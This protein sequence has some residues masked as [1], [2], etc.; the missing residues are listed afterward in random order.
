[1][2]IITSYVA[3]PSPSYIIRNIFSFSTYIKHLTNGVISAANF[4]GCRARWYSVIHST[5]FHFMFLLTTLWL[6]CTV[7]YVEVLSDFL[8]VC[9]FFFFY[10]FIVNYKIW[11]P[12]YNLF[13]KNI[14]PNKCWKTKPQHLQPSCGKIWRSYHE[15]IFLVVCE[16]FYDLTVSD[17][18]RSMH[19]SLWV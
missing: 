9:A 10:L 17:L 4:Q 1:M 3:I 8:V 7:S 15:S 5:I 2:L 12:S 6:R 18:D 14:L 19:R 13:W 11:L 16:P